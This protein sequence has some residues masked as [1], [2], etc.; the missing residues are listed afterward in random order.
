MDY[1]EL[2]LKTSPSPV[3]SKSGQ[4]ISD[5]FSSSSRSMNVQSPT[6]VR[7]TVAPPKP[8][9]R[10][11]AIFFSYTSLMGIVDN[12]VEVEGAL[13][14]GDSETRSMIIRS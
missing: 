7:P 5:W 14:Y 8:Y 12:K 9:E 2:T 1:C 6:T 13:E 11:M 10:L 4:L 3:K